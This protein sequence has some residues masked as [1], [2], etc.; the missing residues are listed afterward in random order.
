VCSEAKKS[1]KLYTKSLVPVFMRKPNGKPGM[2][3]R[4]CTRDYKLNPIVRELRRALSVQRGCKKVIV[5]QWIGISLDEAHRMKPP[6]APWMQ[7]RYPLV[8]G[9]ITRQDCLCWMRQHGFPQP[10]RSACVFC[11]YHSDAEWLRLKTEEPA[12]FRKAVEWER[13]YQSSVELDEVTDGVPFLHKSLVQIGNAK[14][15]AEAIHADQFGNECEG[16]CGV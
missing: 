11:P 9:E 14:F 4:R 10:P 8:D 6:L 1:G 5:T 2:L 12:A 15:D 7:N 13:A 16:M 3:M